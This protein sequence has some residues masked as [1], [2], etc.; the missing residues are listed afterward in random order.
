MP[1]SIEK[2]VVARL[3]YKGERFEILVDPEKA[4]EIRRGK[5]VGDISDVL[6]IPEVYKDA[7]KAERIPEEELQKAFGTTDI[8]EIA[9]RIIRK[10]E[11]QLTSEQRKEMIESKKQQIASIISKRGINPQTGLPHPPQRVLKAMEQVGVAIDPFEDAEAQVERVVK[12]I[13]SVLPISFQKVKFE[14]RVPAAYAGRAYSV[15]KN[16]CES[17]EEKWL[18]DGSLEA[19]VE[20]LGGMQ[21]EL[22]QKLA[23]ATHGDFVSK[24]LEK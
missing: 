6:A 8:A 17:V 12:A 13:S 15:L 23:S 1:V 10:G 14:I 9:K 19:R 18:E 3:W 16:T 11:I 4:L 24:K 21:E 2:A 7:R 5:E 20:V 22:F